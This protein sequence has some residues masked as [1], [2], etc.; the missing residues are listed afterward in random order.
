M[1][2]RPAPVWS[3]M[4]VGRL[5]ETSD[6]VYGGVPPK[7]STWLVVKLPTV[8][9]GIVKNPLESAVLGL[10]MNIAKTFETVP[11]APVTVAVKVPVWLN[12]VPDRTP[13]ELRNNPPK[14]AGD[15]VQG[16]PQ[17]GAWSVWLK[18]TLAVAING[19]DVVIANGS[20]VLVMPLV[21]VFN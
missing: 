21:S 15:H 20:T 13:F 1:V 14:K 9:S 4:P 10:E 6:T 8:W 17:F 19:L 12:G 2:H 18:N 3:E 11:F 5:P 16:E 7:G